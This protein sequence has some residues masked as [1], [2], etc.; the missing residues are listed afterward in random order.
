ML[1]KRGKISLSEGVFRGLPAANPQPIE[2]NWHNPLALE[3]SKL[4][5]LGECEEP[6]SA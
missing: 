4:P 1:L 3:L 6:K 5:K 2:K